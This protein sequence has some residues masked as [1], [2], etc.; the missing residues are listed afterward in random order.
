MLKYLEA[1]CQD[2]CS[3]LSEGSGRL[4]RE[5]ADGAEQPQTQAAGPRCCVPCL[6][7]SH[8]FEAS[9]NKRLVGKVVVSQ[10]R[11][12]GGENTL[13]F[14]INSSIYTA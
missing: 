8:R 7:L 9:R 1:K 14:L 11:A 2:T 10:S 13:A 12:E 3:W 6:S 4:G 5:G